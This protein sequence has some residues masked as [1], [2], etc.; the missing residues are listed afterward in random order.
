MTQFSET[1]TYDIDC[2]KGDGGKVIKV[3]VRN[4]HQRYQC[5]TCKTKFRDPSI[6]KGKQYPI[7]QVGAAL[8]WYF[9]GLSYRE[10]ARQLKNTFD[11][12]AP[13]ENTIYQWV[14]AYSDEA[15]REAKDVKAHTGPEW[16]A[17]ETDVTIDGEH[18]WLWLVMDSKTRYILAALLTHRRDARQAAKVMRMAKDAAA[19]LP[20]RIRTDRMKSYPSAIKKVFD[21]K[22][23]HVQTDGLAAVVNNN[24]IERLNGTVKE[25][26][27]V[28]RGFKRLDSAQQ[29]VDGWVLDYNFFRPHLALANGKD[30]PAS[31]AKANPPFLS[32]EGVARTMDA[33]GKVPKATRPKDTPGFKPKKKLGRRRTIPRGRATL[34]LEKKGRPIDASRPKKR[35]R[36]AVVHSERPPTQLSLDM[37]KR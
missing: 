12:P 36:K 23:E 20:K 18:H 6:S 37:G 9:D 4:G 27:K 7:K 2:P 34:E 24:L 19:N 29:Y 11:I 31:R 10:V 15:V 14:Q 3:G 35:K 1:I 8:G 13:T 5:K 25:R 26:D 33:V 32:W 17:D 28:F 21:G 16:V 22:V 30:T